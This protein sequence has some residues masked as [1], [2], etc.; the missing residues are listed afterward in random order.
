MI[1]FQD[2]D[3]VRWIR[4]TYN[5]VTTMWG[6]SYRY[7]SDSKYSEFEVFTEKTLDIKLDVCIDK[8]TKQ[9]ET[10][11]LRQILF[12][13]FYQETSDEYHKSEDFRKMT[14]ES[15]IEKSKEYWLIE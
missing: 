1:S 6:Y 14:H 5:D 2:D 7:L 15:K 12:G 10:L 3:D 13:D 9:I 8:E 4:R 11:T